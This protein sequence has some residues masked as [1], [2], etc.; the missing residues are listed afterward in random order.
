MS[1]LYSVVGRLYLRRHWLAT[2]GVAVLSVWLCYHVVFGANGMIAYRQK[3]NDY[4]QIQQELQQEQSENEKLQQR[5]KALKTDPQ[6][7]EKE[8]REQFKYAKPGEVIY[9]L[10]A[11]K[12]SS[13]P[14][15]AMAQKH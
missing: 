14:P 3:V 13:P 1:A 12:P 8:A 2:S 11:P 9:L 10:P 5:I 4:K 6:A 7:I 15:A